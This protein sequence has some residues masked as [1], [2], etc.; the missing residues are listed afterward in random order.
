MIELKSLAMHNAYHIGQIVF[1]SKMQAVKQQC[2]IGC[3]L[4]HFE[5]V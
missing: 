5:H 3:P 2:G 1:L 4:E